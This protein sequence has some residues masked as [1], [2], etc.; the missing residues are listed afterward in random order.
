MITKTKYPELQ[1]V[2]LLLIHQHTEK[3]PTKKKEKKYPSHNKNKNKN[4][5]SRPSNGLQL[6]SSSI[7]TLP[8]MHLFDTQTQ[9][10]FLFLLDDDDDDDED[11]A[12][13][14]EKITDL[15][16]SEE[17]QWP[18]KNWK[19]GTKSYKLCK[20]QFSC[21]QKPQNPKHN[22][23]PYC[24]F[25]LPSYHRPHLFI[26]HQ[27][28]LG[29]SFHP[30]PA[31][32]Y[33]RLGTAFHPSPTPTK[34]LISTCTLDA[35][36]YILQ[37]IHSFIHSFIPSFLPSFIQVERNDPPPPPVFLFSFSFIQVES[38]PTHSS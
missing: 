2:L 18:K 27:P 14:V 13:I 16:S 36:Y 15:L 4:K 35:Y 25:H 3:T 9:D 11:D 38:Y 28:R 1:Q 5:K 22:N 30:I 37:F 19:N 6:S 26:Q 17:K 24:F 31:P 29:T 12:G 21:A 8:Q 34:I 7:K 33:H 10:C 20:T 23:I 32:S